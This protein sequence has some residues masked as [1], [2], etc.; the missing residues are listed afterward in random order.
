MHLLLCYD[1]VDDRR[2]TR[3]FRHARGF[4]RPVQ[5][6]VFEGR[7]PASRVASLL[8]EVKRIIDPETD[9]VRVYRLC[10]G[11]RDWTLVLGTAVVV[12]DEVEDVVV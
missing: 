2:R 6:S 3:L 12:P 10:A 9:T 5:E 1:V 4:L 7:V 8:D 11:C